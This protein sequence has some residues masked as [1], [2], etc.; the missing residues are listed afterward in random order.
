MDSKR[1]IEMT[2]ALDIKG[3]DE[4]QKQESKSIGDSQ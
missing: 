4:W 3:D 2:Q 1:V